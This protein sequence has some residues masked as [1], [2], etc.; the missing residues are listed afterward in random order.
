MEQRY[1]NDNS[2]FL[3]LADTYVLYKAPAAKKL[4]AETTYRYGFIM[5]F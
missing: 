4:F 2:P 3:V 5:T 1:V